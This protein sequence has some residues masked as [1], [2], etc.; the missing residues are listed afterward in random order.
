M[1]VFDKLGVEV[2]RPTATAVQIFQSGPKL[3]DQLR[4]TVSQQWHPKHLLPGDTAGKTLKS[5]RCPHADDN[6]SVPCANSSAVFDTSSVRK[7]KQ[8][9]D[10][11]GESTGLS[12]G[13]L[14]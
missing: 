11:Q 5:L 7:H 8:P 13:A 14:C 10:M 6:N 3:M 12:L 2:C 1:C 9:V 4:H